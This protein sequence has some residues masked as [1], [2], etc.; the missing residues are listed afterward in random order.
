MTT[1]T[2]TTADYAWRPDDVAFAAED[3]VPQAL[4]LTT[5]TISGD[6]D[7]DQ[8]S[9]HVAFV[10]DAGQ[11]GTGAVYKAEGA[12]LVDEEPGLDEVLVHT[13]KLTRLA[14]ISN[15]QF[16]K[17][18]TAHQVATSFAR[19]LVRK[20]DYDY[21][22][23]VSNPTGL[24]NASG[25]THAAAPVQDSL[26]ALV[27]LLAELEVLGANPSAIILDPLSWAAFRK[28][29]VAETYNESLLGAGTA[30]ATPMLLS[31]PVKR[32]RFLPENTGLVVDKSAIASAVGPVRV[33][34]SEHAAFRSDATVVKATWRIGW[35]PVRPERIGQ[36]TVGDITGS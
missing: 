36:F 6:I 11:D 33:S 27:D 8:P 30:D 16:R 12:D 21:L 17:A 3:V 10:T 13:K 15:E 24:L 5:S 29:K 22:G 18:P 28:F 35:T 34:Q 19:D 25:I 7:G 32:S 31:L 14:T 2:T 23:S 4:I 20:A 26:D 1:L 9:L